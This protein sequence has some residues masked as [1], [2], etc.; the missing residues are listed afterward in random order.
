M[1]PKALFKTFGK[2]LIFAL[3]VLRGE[4]ALA[5]KRDARASRER[6]RLRAQK[7][8]FTIVTERPPFA[9]R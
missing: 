7:C 3:N 2:K 9:R 6:S 4:A 1:S 8:F 5:V